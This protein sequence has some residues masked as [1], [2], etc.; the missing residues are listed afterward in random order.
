MIRHTYRELRFSDDFMFCKV[1]QNNPDIAK[2]LLELIIGRKVDRIITD[3]SQQSIK[4]TAAGKGVRFDVYLE[5]DETVYDIEMQ[6]SD[7][8]DLPKRSRYYQGMIDLNLIQA[9]AKYR[10]LKSAYIVFIDT[11]DLFGKGLHKYT[12]SNI[13]H[14]DLGLELGDGTMKI[15]LNAVGT[16]D[17][18]SDDMKAF[19]K[20]VA[21]G[22]PG[23]D[24]SKRIDEIVKKAR[25]NKEWEVEYMT[26]EQKLDE[27]REEG[28]A[29]GIEEKSR[30]T[31]TGMIKENLSKD[32]IMRVL[33]LSEE[34]Y[35][36]YLSI[37]NT[38]V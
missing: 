11:F 33:D 7:S 19:L 24:L 23:S 5:D 35:N 28:I 3:S 30:E 14:E 22:V 4:I 27:S 10:E 13:C 16:A 38:E 37:C 8:L 29:I 17:D 25:T 21:S 1:L 2:E 31:F 26:F 12:F 6:T 18:V 9:G 15:F 20:Y 32:V 34:K 36:E